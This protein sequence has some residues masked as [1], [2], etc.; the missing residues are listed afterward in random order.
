MG[1]FGLFF[2]VVPSN[3]L[4]KNDRKFF[5]LLKY[6]LQNYWQIHDIQKTFCF[7]TSK[8]ETIWPSLRKILWKT[9]FCLAI[10]FP[11]IPSQYLLAQSQPWKHKN[12]VISNNVIDVVLCLYGWLWTH[13]THCSGLFIVNSKQVNIMLP[14]SVFKGCVRYIFASLFFCV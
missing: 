13:F 3:Q 8:F 4:N 11:Y 14:F 2:S 5:L 6:T 1:N 10:I 12:N 9:G 7:I